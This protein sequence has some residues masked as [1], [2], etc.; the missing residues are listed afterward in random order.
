MKFCCGKIQWSISRGEVGACI[1]LDNSPVGL[2]PGRLLL[3]PPPSAFL[4][5]P[6]YLGAPS[7]EG[8]HH[9]KVGY[10]NHTHVC[11]H[12][13]IDSTPGTPTLLLHGYASVF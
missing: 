2:T 9:S 8:D 13:C 7:M 12:T 6:T 11:T 4:E 3:L 1:Y 10:T 5:T